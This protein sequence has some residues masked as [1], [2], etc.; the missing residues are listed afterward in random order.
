MLHC[1]VYSAPI[2]L[3]H[4]DYDRRLWHFTRSADTLDGPL[5]GS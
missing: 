3:F 5:A 4:P 2:A 1:I